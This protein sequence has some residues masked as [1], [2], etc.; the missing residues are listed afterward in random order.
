MSRKSFEDVSFLS[1]LSNMIELS[2]RKLNNTVKGF[3][4]VYRHSQRS[5]IRFFND[6]AEI[7]F[8]I[9]E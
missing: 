5:S 8:L 1:L 9:T 4:C 7:H 6:L 2:F 3:Y